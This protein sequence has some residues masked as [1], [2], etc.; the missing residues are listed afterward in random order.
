MKWT[1]DG[2]QKESL[3]YKTRK[4]FFLY[5]RGAYSTASNLRVLN[6]ITKH[7]P[8][9]NNKTWNYEELKNEA[10]KYK[11]RGEFQKKSNSAW[12][13]AR[14]RKLLDEICS[15]MPRRVDS[16][17]ENHHE[18]KWSLDFCKQEALKYTDRTEFSIKSR[19][20][21]RSALR[22]KFLD[23][24]CSHMK[25]GGPSSTL[26]KDLFKS[27]KNIYPKTQTLR[28]R[29][30]RKENLIELKP[31]IQGFE[32]DIYIPE[33]RKAIEFDGKYWHSVKGLK[34]SRE[35]WPEE[36]LEAYH[37]IKDEY[38]K[39]KGIEILHV[40]EEEWLKNK[41]ACIDKCLEFL[42]KIKD[43]G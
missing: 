38:F 21:Y 23:N 31:H 34:R 24:I 43:Y 4:D 8:E 10:F 29:A 30:S 3:K 32:L 1:L 6:E 35:H 7:M 15:H 26:E 33:L 9:A 2:L 5:S 17:N 25:I 39:S 19:G 18:F 37:K 40:R 42:G 12:Q 16:K 22:Q 13:V 14:N 27:I 28:V 36:D 20:A 41:Q 11:T